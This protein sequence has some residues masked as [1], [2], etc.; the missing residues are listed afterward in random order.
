MSAIHKLAHAQTKNLFTGQE[1]KSLMSAVGVQ[2]D[3]FY[4]FMSNLSGQGYFIKKAN[5]TYQ[6][7]SAD[8]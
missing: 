3:N 2:V 6:L 7:L 8:F 5:G 4:D 1:L